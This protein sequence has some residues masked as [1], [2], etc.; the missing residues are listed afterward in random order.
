MVLNISVWS[1]RLKSKTLDLQT[2]ADY[3]AKQ[4]PTLAPVI[5]VHGLPTFTPHTNYY[6]ELVDS[7]ISQ[8]LSVK[9]ARA[10]E[11]R[12]IELFGGNFPTPEQILNR[13]I[14]EFRSVGLSRPKAA[15]IQDL[16]Q[17]VLDG[18]VTFDNLD[19]LSNQ[20]IIDELTKV[21]GIG[22]WTVHMFL[23]FCMRRLDVLPIGDLGIRNGVQKLYGL[24]HVPSPDEVTAIAKKH[25]WSPYESAASWY[26]WQSLNNAP[27]L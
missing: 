19:E 20:E 13:S 1:L 7:I 6:Q 5:A 26:V 9:A 23:M 24:D 14:D 10:I 27:S 11:Q 25:G 18:T 15:Y 17:K 4:D 2:A 22:T 8:Q 21:K 3:L 12:F 16:A